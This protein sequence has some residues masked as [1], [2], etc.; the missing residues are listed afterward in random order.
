MQDAQSSSEEGEDDV[1]DDEECSSSQPTSGEKN[2]LYGKPN[3]Y[4]RKY[5]KM[6]YE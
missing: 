5:R 6:E 2:F 3:F 1:D 4:K